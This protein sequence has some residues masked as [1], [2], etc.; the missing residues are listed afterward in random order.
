MAKSLHL[1]NK[2][3]TILALSALTLFVAAYLPVFQILFKKWVSSEEYNHAFLTLPIIIYMIWVKRFQL[4]ERQVQYSPFGLFIV[5]LATLA[6]YFAMLTQVHTI[7][8]LSM[9][10]TILGVLIY[11]AGVNSIKELFTPLLLLLILI[12][13]PDQLYIKLTFPLQL[14]VSQASEVIVTILGV[15]LYREGNI[16]NIPEKSFEVVEA[17]SG[18]RSIIALLTLSL[19]MGYFMLKK[20]YAKVILFIASIPTAI[21]VNIVRVTVMIL[22][23]HFFRIDLTKGILHNVTGLMVFGIALITLFTLL[24]VLKIWETK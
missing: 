21:A 7:I 12:P 18:L 9:F 20:K 6:Y 17:C 23:F 15:P 22:L 4:V 11:L 3:P 24:K 8:T 10:L 13:I 16:M 5:V 1:A 19:I 14:K 2:I